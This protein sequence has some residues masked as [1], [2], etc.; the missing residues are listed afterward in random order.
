MSRFYKQINSKHFLL[1]FSLSLFIVFTTLFLFLPKPKLSFQELTDQLFFEDITTDTISLHYTLAYPSHYSIN[2]Y[3]LTLPEYNQNTLN[4]SKLKIENS[5]AILSSTD[6][7]KL[8]LEETY[9]HNLLLDY[10]KMQIKGFPF[11]YYEECFSPS[12][13]IAA[14]YPILMA[15]YTFRTKKD[16]TDYL[17]LLKD[18]P[19][20]FSDYFQFQ[21][22][23][24]QKGHYLA[25][26]SLQETL[27]Q[28]DTIIT[29]ESLNENSHFLQLTFRERLMPLVAKDLISKKEAYLYIEENHNI[30]KTIVLP[31]YQELKS[32]LSSL[33]SK[34]IPLQG[35]YKKEH[36]KNYYQ[37]LGQKQVGCSLTIPELLRKLETDYEKNLSEFLFL[38]EKIKTFPNY[39]EYLQQPFPLQDRNEMLKL[40]QKFAVIYIIRHIGVIINLRG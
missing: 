7:S 35:L 24:A 33:Y 32:S 40:L 5:L 27:N 37:W 23:R 13:G 38:Q 22:E 15:E 11:S 20:Y 8:S 34:N 2:S 29:K 36:G 18:T 30:L 10:F 25:S 14:N 12:S 16:V 17:S 19:D 21:K 1:Y 4:E 28:C 9:C 31:A 39:E 6:I 26:S 3:P